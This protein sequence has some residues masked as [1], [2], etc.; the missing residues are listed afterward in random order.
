MHGEVGKAMHSSICNGNCHENL[1]EK[2]EK[3]WVFRKHLLKNSP[4]RNNTHGTIGMLVHTLTIKCNH[5]DP[6]LSDSGVPG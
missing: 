5:P 2:M 6:N 3:I 4:W 1:S